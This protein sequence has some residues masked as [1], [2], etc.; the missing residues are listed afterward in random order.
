MARA[1]RLRIYSQEGG[2]TEDDAQVAERFP[3]A[4]PP[5]Q[6]NS[7][8]A[9]DVLRLLRTDTQTAMRQADH[10]DATASTALYQAQQANT[11]VAEIASTAEQLKA[12]TSQVEA[13]A[14]EI[15][16][17][18]MAAI[19]AATKSQTTAR[20]AATTYAA[21]V[22]HQIVVLLLHVVSYLLDRAPP[23]LALGAAVWLWQQ[24]LEDPNILRLIALGMFGVLVMGPVL[25]LSTRGK[26]GGN[27]G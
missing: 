6:P 13:N 23:L 8:L 26:G 17:Q 4:P 7:Q 20:Q 16:E 5:V 21:T 1:T 15:G 3:A 10:A 24:V 12:R 19:E 11:T 27:A 9:E 18:A 14:R 2:E 25:W 22:A